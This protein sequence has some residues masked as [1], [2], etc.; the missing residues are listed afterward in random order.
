MR[1]PNESTLIYL[2]HNSTTQIEQ[3]VLETLLFFLSTPQ[4][5]NKNFGNV[6]SIHWAGRRLKNAVEDARES[7]ATVLD[8]A[9]PEEFCFTSG[10]TEAT[11]M[12]LKGAYFYFLQHTVGAKPQDFQL[13]ST[14][15][16]HEATLETANFLRTLGATIHL[17]PVD[18][19]GALSLP[20]VEDLLR[21]LKAN[22]K[23]FVML[24]ALAANNETGV[25]FPY[26]EMGKMCESLGVTYH[27]DAVQALGKIKNF[28]IK[29]TKADF[30]SLSAHKIGGPK[31]VGTLY[32]K[33]GKKLVNLLH[34]GA[35]ERKRRAGTVNVPGV[36]AFGKA[37][38][39]LPERNI[40]ALQELRD[41]LEAKVCARIKDSQI[42][43]TAG[44]RIANTVNFLFD[45]V[46]GEALI[47]G[48]DLAGFAVSSGSA[49]NSGSIN[50]SHVL[51]A[52]GLDK[53]AAA[54]AM[55]VSLSPHNTKEE[56]DLFVDALALVVERI[57]AQGKLRT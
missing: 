25:I 36:V 39:L 21:G 27:L 10:A 37:V 34:G 48:L 8:V 31:G 44:P 57:R 56:I 9:D 41:I 17:L 2:D 19:N 22:S 28:S 47:M 18:K 13:V 4:D 45:G 35:Q 12:A 32:I 6:S 46:R 1:T 55:R 16:E 26:E 51:L 15:V 38:S 20:A 11:N 54:S 33:K 49:C 23:N 30:V 50:P 43:G 40:L 24:S 42:Q 29:N 52:M 3:G 53:L 5:P 14:A 7:M